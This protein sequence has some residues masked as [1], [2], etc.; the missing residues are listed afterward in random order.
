MDKF[1][2]LYDQVGEIEIVIRGHPCAANLGKVKRVIPLPSN[3][4]EDN[5]RRQLLLKLLDYL[6]VLS[7]FKPE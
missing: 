6:P 4:T 2:Q 3:D 1:N 5:E 7:H